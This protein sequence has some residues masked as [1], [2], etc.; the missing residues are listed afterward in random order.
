MVHLGPSG[1]LVEM[2]GSK[3]PAPKAP[4][5]QD[6]E[7]DFCGEAFIEGTPNTNSCVNAD[8]S[9]QNNIEREALCKA[10]ADA[11]GASSGSPNAKFM[12]DF[13]HKDKCPFGCFKKGNV[14]FFNADGEK[15]HH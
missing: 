5:L 13:N 15:P 10:A 11:A 6:A 2:K 7:Q 8:A 12:V 14:F 9:I 1:E 3:K 4:P